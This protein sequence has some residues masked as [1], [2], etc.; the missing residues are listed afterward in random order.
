M[1]KHTR[2]WSNEHDT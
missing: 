1:L 2:H